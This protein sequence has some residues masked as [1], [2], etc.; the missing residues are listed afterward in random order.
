ML[1]RL[2][3]RWFDSRRTKP[4]RI[5]RRRRLFLEPLEDRSLLS[6]FTVIN[7]DATG[8]GSL[9]E[10]MFNAKAT[11]NV[12]G[13]GGIGITFPPP[14]PGRV[15]YGDDGVAGQLTPAN[16]TATTAADDSGIADIDP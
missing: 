12:G 2:L 14:D 16:V 13:P 6:T 15:Y 4:C 9:Y 7:T 1:S 10:A 11:P 8:P 3:C 5:K